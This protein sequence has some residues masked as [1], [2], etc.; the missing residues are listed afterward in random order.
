MATIPVPQRGQPIDFNYI[1]TIVQSL[2]ELSS[3]IANQSKHMNF[4][5]SDGTQESM[6]ASTMAIDIAHQTVVGTS[7]STTKPFTGTYQFKT[8]FKA[9]PIVTITVVQNNTSAGNDDA[10]VQITNTSASQVDYQVAFPGAKA[11]AAASVSVNL[12]AIG[13]AQNS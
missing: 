2:N 10:I 8:K 4:T 9:T 11:K 12:I 1:Y 3:S 6:D 13:L 5:H 7:V